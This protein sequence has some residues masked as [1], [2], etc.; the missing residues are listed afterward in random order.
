MLPT[1]LVQLVAHDGQEIGIGRTDPAIQIEFDDR[2]GLADGRELTLTVGLLEHLLRHV[3]RVLDDLVGSA[4]AAEDGKVGR[5]NPH[6]LAILG[7]ALVERGLGL[8]AA[9]PLPERTVFGGIAQGLVDEMPVMH[10]TQICA[11]IAGGLGEVVVGSQY[12]A[13]EIELDD[14]QQAADRVD[15]AAQVSQTA[16]AP[17]PAPHG[18]RG[19]NRIPCHDMRFLTFGGHSLTCLYRPNTATLDAIRPPEW[20]CKMSCASLFAQP[21]RS[22]GE[23]RRPGRHRPTQAVGLW[24]KLAGGA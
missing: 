23:S 22:A 4:P 10:A 19:C 5:L 20:T 2:L 9:Q 14:G 8:T 16:A 1:Q 21:T 13:I 18:G 17:D 3:H 15:V 11:R 12:V 6:R 24:R 7:L